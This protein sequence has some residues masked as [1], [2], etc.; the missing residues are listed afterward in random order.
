MRRISQKF[1]NVADM[2]KRM[3]SFGHCPNYLS[4][5]PH[6]GQLVPL[7][8][9]VKNDVLASITEQSKDDYDNDVSD[10][11]DHNFGTFDDFGVKN[12]Q[13]V[14]NNMILMSKYKGKHGGK[15]GQKIRAWV[16]PTP[17]IRAIPERKRFFSIDVFPYQIH[18]NN[19]KSLIA[20]P[21]DHRSSAPLLGPRQTGPESKS[22]P[23]PSVKKTSAASTCVSPLPVGRSP[24][25]GR[26]Q[27]RV[28]RWSSAWSR[29]LPTERSWR[30]EEVFTSGN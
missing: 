11:C 26:H 18:W 2:K 14:S 15:K 7:F 29:A 20:P 12:D 9:D 24:V 28:P 16:D 21:A 5:P 27:P 25:Q 1:H 22:F 23:A 30:W 8:L 19:W 10:N 6:F 13:K 17:L 4:L 3:F